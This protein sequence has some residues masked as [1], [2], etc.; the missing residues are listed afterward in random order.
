MKEFDTQ[1]Q[2]SSAEPR[3]AMLSETDKSRIPEMVRRTL[4]YENPDDV[5]RLQ[6]QISSSGGLLRVFVH[7]FYLD[8]KSSRRTENSTETQHRLASSYAIV[9]QGAIRHIRAE[10]KAPLIVLEE[11]GVHRPELDGVLTIAT[12]TS[13]GSID[14]AL[15]RQVFA[16]FDVYKERILQARKRAQMRIDASFRRIEE[17]E[18]DGALDDYTRQL[19]I[20]QHRTN[21]VHEERKLREDDFVRE[22]GIEPLFYD[23]FF[24]YLGVR[25]LILGGMFHDDLP[26]GSR[27]CL[28]QVIGFAKQAGIPVVLSRY[29]VDFQGKNVQGRELA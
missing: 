21:I 14:R 8:G 23:T 27:G 18:S 25:K 3:F 26:E 10:G 6:D 15:L 9:R 1:T 29:H 5:H 2:T 4:G 12:E 16:D 11:Q 7:P 24:R 22:A 13:D 19:V 17:T 28:S 20:A